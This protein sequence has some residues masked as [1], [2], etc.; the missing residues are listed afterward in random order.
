MASSALCFT[1]EFKERGKGKTVLALHAHS[2]LLAAQPLARP[3]RPASA[4]TRG[5][6]LIAVILWLSGVPQ[7]FAQ[8]RMATG[9]LS[10]QVRPEELLQSQGSSVKLK[11]RLAPGTTAHLWAAET[12]A[13][14][15]AASQVIA[16][17]GSYSIPLNS[18]APASG[19]F[20][21]STMRVCLAS[22]D[23]VLKDSVAAEFSRTA[24][25]AP[26]QAATPGFASNIIS[27]DLPTGWAVTTQAGVTTWSNP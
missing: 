4:R 10:V 20:S 2:A 8:G 13:S 26:L 1:P 18:F 14:P 19:Y 7:L 15:G 23:G 24:L 11:I 3:L 12:C 17:S 27:F 25:G 6:A 22:S 21:P 9:I 5:A 16:L